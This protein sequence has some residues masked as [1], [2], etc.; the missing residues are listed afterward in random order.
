M[1][2]SI[3]E[4]FVDLL[5]KQSIVKLITNIMSMS[6]VDTLRNTSI[7]WELIRSWAGLEYREHWVGGQRGEWGAEKEYI[8]EE[9]D[10][11]K[12]DDGWE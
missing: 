6:Q 3:L 2:S 5:S 1:F 4:T 7:V 8:E 9:E 11:D 12:E 10:G